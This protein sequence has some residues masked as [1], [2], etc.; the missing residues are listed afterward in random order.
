MDDYLDGSLGQDKQNFEA[1]LAVCKGCAEQ[2][3]F[4]RVYR[5]EVSELKAERAPGDF[6]QKLHGRLGE[7]APFMAHVRRLG[8]VLKGVVYGLE[9][10]GG[11][12]RNVEL[13]RVGVTLSNPKIKFPLE[14]AGVAAVAAVALLLFGVFD[15]SAPKTGG[16]IGKTAGSRRAAPGESGEEVPES[17]VQPDLFAMDAEEFPRDEIP[18]ILGDDGAET[19]GSAA[20]RRP[21]TAEGAGRLDDSAPEIASAAGPREEDGSDGKTSTPDTVS[22]GMYA[23]GTAQLDTSS[24]GSFQPDTSGSGSYQPDTAPSESTTTDTG[25]SSSGSTI[26]ES[27]SESASTPPESVATE[28][29]PSETEGGTTSLGGGSGSDPGTSGSEPGTGEPSSNGGSDGDDLIARSGLRELSQSLRERI[30]R[31]RS[32]ASE[33]SESSAPDEPALTGAQGTPDEPALTGAQETPDEPAEPASTEPQNTPVDP[34]NTSAAQQSTPAVPRPETGP[35]RETQKS[36]LERSP[37]QLAVLLPSIPSSP[38]PGTR[39]PGAGEAEDADDPD[40]QA[41][42][43]GVFREEYLPQV[44]TTIESLGGEIVF[45]EYRDSSTPALINAR[46]PSSVY[47]DLIRA[48]GEYGKVIEPAGSTQDNIERSTTGA[49]SGELQIQIRFVTSERPAS[50]EE[51]SR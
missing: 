36:E 31:A 37:M 16:T 40:D 21:A 38:E 10:I 3:A 49:G 44:V 20:G 12:V 22:G 11:L 41:Q 39:S 9:H 15:T 14:A 7:R 35:G 23:S 25:V 6:L 32:R 48:L 18:R 45:R 19:A 42:T 46:I 17:E 51:Q 8:S 2:L 47:V 50:A 13:S 34:E 33:D 5:R 24:S 29:T 28:S 27:D 26:S 4:L 30:A 1:H 43:S